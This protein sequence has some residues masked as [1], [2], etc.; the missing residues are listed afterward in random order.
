MFV[1]KALLAAL[2]I[3]AGV[4]GATVVAKE[5]PEFVVENRYRALWA[6]NCKDWDEW[7][8]RALPFKVYGNTQ[9]IGT[10]GISVILIDSGDGV[11]IIDSGPVEASDAVRP[12]IYQ[13]HFR[14][15]DVKLLLQSHEHFDHVGGMAK[16]RQRTGAA[17][18]AS[19]AAAPVM[20]SG[21]ASEDDPQYGMHPPFPAA[22]VDR[23]L[24]GDMTVTLGHLTLHAIETPGHTPGALTWYWK[25]CEGDVCK[26][27]VYADSLTPVSSDD[28]HFSDHP[29]Y[30][31]QF[32]ASLDKVAALDCDIL[33]A[34][35][36]SSAGMR[37]KLLAGDLAGP[38][39]CKE[40]ADG[41]RKQLDE[42]LA[43]EAAGAKP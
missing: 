17:L 41:L 20:A 25:S 27:I 13:A 43:K 40:Y 14:E 4:G 22:R 36:P 19:R 31:A 10:C 33:L 8:K 39:L 9:Y 35:H 42:R 2:L 26:T 28:Y 37:D 12:N 32:R 23:V 1:R 15:H 7:N 5:Q 6:K 34:P 11:V 3:S 29:E 24:D 21:Q 16:L 18:V 30:V 38:P